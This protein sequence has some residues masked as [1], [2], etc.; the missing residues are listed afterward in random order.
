A[1]A[2]SRTTTP[3]AILTPLTEAA[4]FLTVTVE[5]GGEDPVRDLL[6]DASGVRR[7]VGFR[8]P[9]AGLTCVVG[10][11]ASAWERLFGAPRPAELHPFAELAGEA[12]TAPAT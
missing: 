11:G 9:E 3:Q 6:A 8:I 5:P 10:I 1:R 12:H 2:M 7:S 4:I